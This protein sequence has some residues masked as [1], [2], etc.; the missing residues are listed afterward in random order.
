MER[1]VEIGRAHPGRPLIADVIRENE[2]R[3]D[4]TA[5]DFGAGVAMGAMTATDR[6]IATVQ[7]LLG[8]T[9]GDR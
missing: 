8:D 6:A 3:P 9:D 2:Y 4:R 1:F 5:T 7:G